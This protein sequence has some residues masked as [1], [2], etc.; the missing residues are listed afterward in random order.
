MLLTVFEMNPNGNPN[1]AQYG[2]ATR[3]GAPAAPDPAEVGSRTKP[4]SI[5]LA[6]RH[7]SAQQIDAENPAVTLPPTPTTAQVI[8]AAVLEKAI[9]GDMRAV[10]YLTDQVDGKLPHANIN[11]ELLQ[12]MQMTDEQLEAIV[13]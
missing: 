9:N 3:F 2:R 6:L 11:A 13:G 12:I 5:R 7:L 8:A 4:W 1:I 10:E